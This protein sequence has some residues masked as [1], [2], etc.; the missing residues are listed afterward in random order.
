MNEILIPEDIA[1]SKE[2]E[3]TVATVTELTGNVEEGDEDE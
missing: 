2:E 1:L 3:F